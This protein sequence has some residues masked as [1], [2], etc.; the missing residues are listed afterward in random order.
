MP[1]LYLDNITKAFPQ[2]SAGPGRLARLAA[3]TR[4]YRPRGT[5]PGA[6]DRA[7][8]ATQPP[9]AAPVLRGVTLEIA[10]GEFF[11]L[12]GPSGCGKSTLLRI[13]AGLETLDSGAVRLGTQD[14]S[15]L[16]PQHRGIGFVFQS[17]A[18]WPHLSVRDNLALGLKARKLHSSEIA[19]RIN[20]ALELVE[21]GDLAHRM[22][23]QLSGGQQQRV[24]LARAI[25][26]EPNLILLDE[27]LSN[28]DR[29][30]RDSIRN[31][32]KS[33]QRKIGTTMIFVTHD[34]EEALSMGDRVALLFEGKIAQCGSP[35]ELY[36]RPTSP[37]VAKFLGDT[38]LLTIT[39]M[40]TEILSTV[41]ER[42]ATN[43]SPITTPETPLLYLT[44]LSITSAGLT[45]CATAGGTV[46]M[47][48]ITTAT[49]IVQPDQLPLQHHIAPH[50]L[51]ELGFIPSPATSSTS[52]IPSSAPPTT[53]YNLTCSIRPEDFTIHAIIPQATA[54]QSSD[55]QSTAPQ[56]TSPQATSLAPLTLDANQFLATV[57]A[58]SYVGSGYLLTAKLPNGTPL[59]L[60]CQ[61]A[62]YHSASYHS[63]TYQ[64]ASLSDAR[65]QNLLN[66]NHI[67]APG[68]TL[69]LSLNLDAVVPFPVATTTITTATTTTTT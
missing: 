19:R 29:R 12:L 55:P 68:D 35:Q 34:Q 47:A 37:E 48:A 56:A 65:S 42:P 67:I 2:A 38:N 32:L 7:P 44:N 3:A 22:P 62:S 4:S 15:R 9:N 40:R 52:A 41:T 8:Y 24:A 69:V 59:H 61:S 51:A 66:K 16:A 43:T 63:A 45:T 26:L 30:L 50:S 31:E 11:F 57:T 53:P 23:Q 60:S 13:I 36:R 6:S 58:T 5:P 21:L 49:T 64:S 28:L 33:L 39:E 14:W 1:T 27:P 10:E 54:T 25:A 18:L 20:N 17:Y 46:G